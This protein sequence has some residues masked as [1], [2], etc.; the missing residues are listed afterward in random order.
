METGPWRAAPLPTV[1]RSTSLDQSFPGKSQRLFATE[2]LSA[3]SESVYRTMKFWE[4]FVS[5]Q[6]HG[7]FWASRVVRLLFVASDRVN[8]IAK[9]WA[10]VNDEHEGRII[11]GTRCIRRSSTVIGLFPSLMRISTSKMW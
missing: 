9:G 7:M 1:G 8:A 2:A 5:R 3:E 4:T 10:M 6:E 11:A